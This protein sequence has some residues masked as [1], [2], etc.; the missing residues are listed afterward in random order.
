MNVAS[1]TGFGRAAGSTATLAWTWEIKSVNGRTL[2]I[3]LKLPPGLERLDA[4]VRRA[5]GQA[6]QRGSLQVV[7]LATRPAASAGIRLNESL[8]L[9]LYD[10]LNALAGRRGLAPVPLEALL[11]VRGVIEAEEAAGE[12]EDEAAPDERLMASFGEA[13]SMLAA[14]RHSEGAA[15]LAILT[16]QL[17]RMAAGIAGAASAAAVQGEALR[18]RLHE[19]VASLMEADS[20]LDPQRLHQEA[21]LLAA[22]ADVREELDRFA[23]HVAAARMLLQQGGAIGRRLD[24][25]AQELFRETNTICSKA[26][27]LDL[28]AAGLDI[29]SLVE[30][31]REQVQN[32]E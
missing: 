20:R 26:A 14:T 5:L 25:L 12:L 15:L 24:F 2:D 21:V 11:G 29:K 4:P 7:L 1:M 23:A 28:T 30:Q 17:E 8:L 6:C 19:Q 31:F 32:V 22:R 16:D 10:Q 9:A 27:S 18:R 13:V 3:R